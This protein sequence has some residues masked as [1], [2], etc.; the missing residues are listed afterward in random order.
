[1]HPWC[2]RSDILAYC[3]AHNIVAQAYSPLVRGTR[4]RSATTTETPTPPIPPGSEYLY[5]LAEKYGKTPAQILLRWSLQRG[6]VPIVK[7]VSEERLKENIGVWG[8]EL[9]DAHVEGLLTSEYLP[10]CW[11]PVVDCK[12]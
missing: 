9:Q 10:I 4:F 12:D 8:W 2:P 6:C 11:D 3:T 7:T 5:A 1:M